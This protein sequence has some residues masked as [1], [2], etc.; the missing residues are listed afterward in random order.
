MQIKSA[1]INALN[2]NPGPWFT[3]KGSRIKIIK[4]SE[5]EQQGR[6]G[7]ILGNDLIIACRKMQLRF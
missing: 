3:F 5:V 4:V 6:P 7:E 1:K 2:P